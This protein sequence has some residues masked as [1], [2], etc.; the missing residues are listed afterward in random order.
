M[1]TNVASITAPISVSGTTGTTFTGSSSFS[2]DFQDVIVRA[3]EIASLPMDQLE[4]SQNHLNS[5]STELSTI[6]SSFSSLQNAIQSLQDATGSSSLSSSVSDSNVSVSLGTGAVAG[7]YSIDVTSLGAYSSAISNAGSTT[8]ADPS[9]QSI[10]SDSSLTLTV[11]GNATTITPSA[12]N[13]DALVDALNSQSDGAVQASIINLGST[14]SPDYR[15]SIQ[16]SELAADSIEL[17]DSTGNLLN[18]PSTG[19]PATYQ[20]DGLSTSI[21]S[22]SRTI[23]LA[24]GV[25]VNLLGQSTSGSPSTI[26]VTSDT[27]AA[28]RALSN[29]V[30]AYNSAV[31]ALNNDRGQNTGALNGQGVISSLEQ[32]LQQIGSYISSSGTIRS[33]ADVGVTFN[34]TG[35]LEFDQSTFDTNTSSNSTALFDFLGGATTGGFLEAATNAING[36]EDSTTGIIA[37]ESQGIQSQLTAIGTKITADQAQVNTLQTNLTNQMASADALVASLEQQVTTLNGLFDAE[38]TDSQAISNG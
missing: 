24:P 35:Q 22:S 23:T 15:L 21:S 27:S 11:N 18:T 8:V 3:V 30:S 6:S 9:S 20:L 25:T 26:S 29:F 12:D 34:S 4:T 5:E 38:Q 31:S 13:L 1:S 2:S 32:S 28:N 17:S 36:V 33:L 10:T 16:S 37:T 14:S 19:S 7:S